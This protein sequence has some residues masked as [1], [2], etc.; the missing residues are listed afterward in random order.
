VGEIADRWLD[1]RTLE[2]LVRQYQGLI[3]ADVRRDTRKLDTFEAFE[4]GVERLKTFVDGRRAF[5]K[6][7]LKM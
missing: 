4:S 5:L 3:A 1:W 6:A 2:P 7:R